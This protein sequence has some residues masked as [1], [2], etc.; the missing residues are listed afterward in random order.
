[1]KPLSSLLSVK[2]Y[3]TKNNLYNLYKSVFALPFFI[4]PFVGYLLLLIVLFFGNNSSVFAQKA[5]SKQ[6][7]AEQIQQAQA[8]MGL[9]FK[10]FNSDDGLAQNNVTTILQDTRGF[11]LIG[12]GDGLSRYDGYEFK[13]YTHV[14]EDSSS[15]SAG[16]VTALH[17]DNDGVLWIGT[18]NGIN[19]YDF[20]QDRFVQ[21]RLKENKISN[22]N[23]RT[24]RSIFQD[25]RGI[26]WVGTENGIK[27]YDKLNNSIEYSQEYN[28]LLDVP[29]LALFEDADSTFWVGTENGLYKLDRQRR[30]FVP[31]FVDQKQITQFPV[32]TFFEDKQRNLW[33]GTQEGAFRLDRKRKELKKYSSTS[34][35]NTLSNDIVKTIAQDEKG[36]IW[37]GTYGGGINRFIQKTGQIINIRQNDAE[38]YSLSDDIVQTIYHDRSG[39]IWIGTYDGL[40]KYDEEKEVFYNYPIPLQ[41]VAHNLQTEV[42]ALEQDYLGNTWIGTENGLYVYMPKP[43]STQWELIKISDKIG[44][45]NKHILSLLEDKKGNLWIGTLQDGLYKYSLKS[46]GFAG[47]STSEAIPY[48]LTNLAN[49]SSK[50]DPQLADNSVWTMMQDTYNDIWIGTNNGLYAIKDKTEQVHKYTERDGSGLSD[51]SIWALLQDRYGVLWVGTSNGLNRF[52][53]QSNDFITYNQA[54]DDSGGLSNGYIVTLFEDETGVI[55]AGT[56]GGGLNRFH[57]EADNFTHYTE[58]DGLPDGVIYAIEQDDSRHLWISTNRGLSRFNIDTQVFRNYDVNDGLP[59][60]RFNHNSIEKTKDG[61]LIFGTVYGITVFHPDSI[62]D[63]SYIPP[64]YLT[65]LKIL[66]RDIRANDGTGILSRNIAQTDMI[67]LSHGQNSFSID[68]IAL[69]YRL[70]KKTVYMYKLEGFDEEW[71]YTSYRNHTASYTNLPEGREYILRV[72]AA[73]SDGYWNESGATLRIYINP[74]YWEAIWFKIALAMI[75]IGAAASFWFWRNGEMQKQK[76]RLSMEVHQ[77]TNELEEEKEKLQIAYNE[78]SNQSRQILDMNAV[79]KQKQAEVMAQRDDLSKQRNEIENSYQNVRVLSDIGQQV[80]AT[81]DFDQMVAVLYQHV[82][83]LMNA[84]GFGIGVLNEKTNLIEF[85]G[86]SVE[87]NQLNYDFNAARDKTLLSAWAIRNQKEV[88]IGDL[89]SEYAKYVAGE[90]VAVGTTIPKSLIYLPLAI[91]GRPVGVL[92]VQSL[93]KNTYSERHLTLLKGLASY[94]SIALDNIQNYS[95]LGQAKNTIQESSIRIMD[96]LRYAQTIQQAILPTDDMLQSSFDDSFMI[97][98]PKDVV[99]GDFYW[100]REIEGRT[101]I[102]SVDCTGHG[103]PGAFMSMIGSRLLNEI[104]NE[105]NVLEPAKILDELHLRLKNALKQEESR[106]DDGMDVSLCRIDA[107]EEDTL[108]REIVFAGAKRH[109]V[110]I[111]RGESHILKGDKKS[112]G[113]WRK[114]KKRPFIQLQMTAKKGDALYLFTDGITDQNNIAGAK[115]GSKRLHQLLSQNSDFDMSEQ[116]TIL[117][118]DLARHQGNQKQR[119]DIT[120]IGIRL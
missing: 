110:W 5:V 6:I 96:S 19:K 1:M 45:R 95:E 74:P 71:H 42:W 69:N 54:N 46:L 13:N 70:P 48:D 63:N 80:T 79:L 4:L 112:I 10:K 102:A 51:N 106:N 67:T 85:R 55:W 61:E 94:V 3:L 101:F 8:I 78:I 14:V 58:K 118:E 33:V 17:Q 38:Q 20:T 27:I 57:K 15:L 52:R 34:F 108:E 120:L 30:A 81:L 47:N 2:N 18:T 107:L 73:N 82:N 98:R 23:M 39:I 76:S 109:A 25:S 35:P 89:Q 103:V 24:V 37:I 44:L 114:T 90:V 92:T 88:K 91:K 43:E 105:A 65:N 9:R 72:K 49:K 16:M 115:Y 113:G 22:L 99:S 83:S 68:F 87:G 36:D 62:K 53:K 26:L 7:Q 86:Y 64:V 60:N 56:H 116:K 32:Y 29:V 40:N 84:P 100:L 104:I 97:F 50:T 119:D 41:Y 66:G 11:L 93:E 117:E 111:S 31:A 21:Y 77:R 59:S 12:T 75:L 28:G